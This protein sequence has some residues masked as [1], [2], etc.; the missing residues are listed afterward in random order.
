MNI[1]HGGRRVVGPQ[2]A[3]HAHNEA[4]KRRV[5]PRV[6]AGCDNFVRQV[7]VERRR[8]RPMDGG[9]ARVIRSLFAG[10]VGL[11]A[12]KRPSSFPVTC[13][14]FRSSSRP[15]ARASGRPGPRT[16]RCAR[17]PQPPAPPSPPAPQASAG[18]SGPVPRGR[19][20]PQESAHDSNIDRYR[21]ESSRSP[22]DPLGRD[23]GQCPSGARECS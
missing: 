3:G 5:A 13:P 16:P 10:V 9:E 8:V 22:A 11:I 12:M 2:H 20:A 15:R 19:H 7:V 21:T 17:P 4:L 1:G 14:R 6:Y 18:R 23:A